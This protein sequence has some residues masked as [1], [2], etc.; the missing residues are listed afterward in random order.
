MVNHCCNSGCIVQRFGR[1]HFVASDQTGKNAKSFRRKSDAINHCLTFKVKRKWTFSGLKAK[2]K[3]NAIK[4]QSKRNQ[5]QK[6]NLMLTWL[7]KTLKGFF[8]RLLR[9]TF[10]KWQ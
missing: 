3:S 1:G 4:G 5:G 9:R 8:S 7:W 10:S 2:E 6:R